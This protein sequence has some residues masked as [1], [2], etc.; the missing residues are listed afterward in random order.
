MIKLTLNFSLSEFKE[1]AAALDYWK[2]ETGQAITT[3][4]LL[5]FLVNRFNSLHDEKNTVRDLAAR[6]YNPN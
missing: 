5:T 6:H 2:T 4:Q 3:E 1:M